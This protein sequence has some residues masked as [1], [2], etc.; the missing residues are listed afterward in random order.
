M[1]GSETFPLD[2]SPSARVSDTMRRIPNSACC[3]KRDVHVTCEGRVVRRGAAL[4]S[5]GISD[6]STV[7]IMSRML[8][9]RKHRD[10]TGTRRTE[11]RR[12]KEQKK[13]KARKCVS[14]GESEEA[15][16]QNTDERDAMSG[17]MNAKTGIG[18]GCL[19]R[20]GHE[21]R[22]KGTEVKMNVEA[23]EDLEAEE[24]GTRRRRVNM[25][26]R[27]GSEWRLAW[28][29]VAH[30]PKKKKSGSARKDSTAKRRKR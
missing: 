16:G 25:R 8:G 20:E 7:Q 3:G 28:R 21:R 4:K 22:E 10:N 15:P 2:L 19:V 23:K 24:E 13:S 1:D 30:T 14:E 17:L 6:G 27:S 12:S 5:C 18:S 11:R 29:P 9:G 26:R